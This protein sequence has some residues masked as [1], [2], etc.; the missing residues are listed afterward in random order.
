MGN[1]IGK[2][3]KVTSFGSSHGRAVGAV[4][5]GCPANLELTQKDIQKELDKRKPGTS[6]VTTPR[7]ESDEVQILSGI[8]EGK[9]DGTPITGVVYNKNQHSKDYSMFKNTPR[10]SHGDYGWM[11]KYGNY[12]YNGGG[13]GSGRIT[14]GHVIA[15]AIA[16]K[17]LKTKNIEIISQV[18][19][20]GNI[21]AHNNDFNSI[22]ENIEKNSVRCGDSEAAKAM[23]ELI[24]TK[25]QQGDSIGG[26]VE[27]IATGVPA[28]LGEPVFDRLDGD[29]ARILMNINAVKGVEIGIGFEVANSYASE[30]NDEYYIKNN[31]IYTSTNNSGGIIGGIS[32]GMPIISRIAIKPTPSIS[33]CQKSVNLEK[34][35]EEEISIKGR[36]DPCI[37]PR[38]TIVAQSSVAIVLA[39]H[40]IRSGYIHPSN[41]EI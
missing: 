19:Q 34:M 24:L 23:E 9:T 6:G 39:D 35:K 20:I 22:K 15:G 4:I 28:G 11:S 8:F 17:L 18:V 12:D 33:K 32:N 25:K 31:E 30:I 40:M 1:T 38:A 2:M 14:I 21:K 26:I 13:R 37:C 27:T 10:P 41:L 7:K 3:F 29:L 5:D 36:H 16:K